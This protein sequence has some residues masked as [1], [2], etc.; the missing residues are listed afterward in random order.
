MLVSERRELHTVAAALRS[1]RMTPAEYVEEV[2]D[3][4]ERREPEIQALIPEPG[5]RAR[6]LAE[7]TALEARFSAAEARPPLYGVPVGVK[8]IFNV[9]GF[10][11]RAG[12]ELPP[13]LFGGVEAA[14][15]TTLKRAGALI[16]GK[17]VTT[18]FAYFEPGP[19]RNPWNPNHTPG[20][21]SSG[22]AA[23]VA[24]G[25]CALA[26]GSQTVGSVIRPAAFC[27]VAGFKPTYGLLPTEGVVPYAPS[28]DTGGFFVPD[29]GDLSLALSILTG[30]REQAAPGRRCVGVP[31]GPYLEQASPEGMAAFGDQVARLERR[32]WTVRRI[33][34]LENIVEINRLHQ[35]LAAA[36]MAQVHREWFGRHEDLYRTR[37]AAW[38]REGQQVPPQ[39]AEA[40]RAGRAQLRGELEGLMAANG[41]D[42]WICPA[43]PGPAPEG[44]AATGDPAMNLPWTYAGLPVATILA[45]FAA[46]GLPLGLQCVARAGEDAR[47]AAFACQ[48]R[49]DLEG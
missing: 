22:S 41:F 1:G 27:G 38:I 36:E 44:I 15:V 23:A 6:L 31:V 17:T 43:A 35:R 9:D 10:E 47:L 13:E 2:C 46:N 3:R 26:L 16:L 48:V 12:S 29:A 7:A 32:G 39:V 33:P 30:E 21:S 40:A 20:G 4:I 49:Q 8:D 37:T 24:A 45:G 11:T 28:L 19:T 5:R 34:A 18:E 25:Y 42:V 14:C